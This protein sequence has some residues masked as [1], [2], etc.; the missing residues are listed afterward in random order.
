[1]RAWVGGRRGGTVWGSTGAL[2][3]LSPFS[4]EEMVFPDTSQP[5]SF[6][7]R[8]EGKEEKEDRKVG[9]GVLKSLLG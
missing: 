9:G 7:L 8:V 2:L 1:M 5:L 6:P 3:L 4:K